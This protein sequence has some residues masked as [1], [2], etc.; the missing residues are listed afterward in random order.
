MNWRMIM[1]KSKYF[2]KKTHT[3]KI[4]NEIIQINKYINDSIYIYIYHLKIL[5]KG[6]RK[7]KFGSSAAKRQLSWFDSWPLAYSSDNSKWHIVEFFI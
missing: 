1:S 2:V 5:L 3:I 6:H 4:Y 7:T